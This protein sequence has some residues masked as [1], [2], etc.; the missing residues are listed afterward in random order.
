MGTR[1]R[2]KKH[3]YIRGNLFPVKSWSEVKKSRKPGA[4]KTGLTVYMGELIFSY[5]LV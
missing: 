5:V 1:K 4:T 3:D 2:L